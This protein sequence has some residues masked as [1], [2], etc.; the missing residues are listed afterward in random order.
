MSI[1]LPNGYW[2][3]ISG[4]HNGPVV[5]RRG[6]DPI[7]TIFPPDKG[8]ERRYYLVAY[9][10]NQ[11]YHVD[12]DDDIKNEDIFLEIL[13]KNILGFLS[14]A[15]VR[16]RV[17]FSEECYFDFI[18]KELYIRGKQQ[19]IT[20]IQEVIIRELNTIDYGMSGEELAAACKAAHEYEP[21]EKSIYNGY[22]NLTNL[23]E[24]IKKSFEYTRGGSY[25]STK[26]AIIEIIG[27]EADDAAP[28]AVFAVSLEKIFDIMYGEC[29]F[30]AVNDGNG[31]QYKA[32]GDVPADM[33]P[34]TLGLGKIPFKGYMGDI[35][36]LVSENICTSAANLAE[37]FQIYSAKLSVAWEEVKAALEENYRRSLEESVRSTLPE[38][39]RE[40]VSIDYSSQGMASDMT[41]KVFP[42]IKNV[43]ESKEI[44]AAYFNCCR[45]DLCGEADDEK[46][47]RRIVD[48]VA[49][50]AAALIFICIAGV[51]AGDDAGSDGNREIYI[52][53]LQ[54]MIK[55]KFGIKSPID[56]IIE[57]FRER[58]NE[59]INDSISNPN[60][61]AI[62][63][64][65]D[66]LDILGM[67][68][69]VYN[70][71]FGDPNDYG[72]TKTR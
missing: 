67:N 46:S 9:Y 13:E 14:E 36:Q 20:P 44:I 61:L 6:N 58:L 25:K 63:N 27:K 64:V 52:A 48:D 11:V 39:F 8:R 31:I 47:R 49:D 1:E 51:E 24:A 30:V 17:Y 71:G 12:E 40:A 28:K 22:H 65:R 37:L 23:D 2:Y 72:P 68:S 55:I 10:L 43:I 56:G 5:P 38:V 41:K 70:L 59:A 26:K 33:I 57:T 53:R 62:K 54:E 42:K 60:E 34:E 18:S 35:R 7:L 3:K 21:G 32:P 19:N 16:W 45:R 4:Y 50:Y 15:G 29:A 69:D 66:I